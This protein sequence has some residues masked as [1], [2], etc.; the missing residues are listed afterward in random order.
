MHSIEVLLLIGLQYTAA[1]QYTFLLYCP[2]SNLK[3]Q[4]FALFWTRFYLLHAATCHHHK[5][6]YTCIDVTILCN[7][8]DNFDNYYT[9]NQNLS[10]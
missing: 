5:I 7:Y 9:C 6:I 4:S 1:T 2:Y 3:F 10:I 8:I